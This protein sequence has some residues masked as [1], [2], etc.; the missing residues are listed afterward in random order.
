[1]FWDGTVN[2]ECEIDLSNHPAA[3]KFLDA[4][5][6]DWNQPAPAF[7]THGRNVTRPEAV[8]LMVS[9]VLEMDLLQSRESELPS[10]DDWYTTSQAASLTSIGSCMS[11]HGSLLT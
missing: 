6:G 4:F 9:A 1:M 5:N 10:V 8:D 7:W 11:P 2:D 3:E